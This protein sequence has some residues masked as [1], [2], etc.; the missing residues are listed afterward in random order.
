MRIFSDYYA[1]DDRIEVIAKGRSVYQRYTTRTV[2]LPELMLFK[3]G[4]TTPSHWMG[5]NGTIVLSLPRTIFI[6]KLKTGGQPRLDGPTGKPFC[7]SPC[8]GA[9]C[10]YRA[11]IQRG[12][13]PVFS[14]SMKSFVVAI[15]YIDAIQSHPMDGL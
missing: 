9:I 11:A 12:W 8:C 2:E 10:G 5:L 14:L 6:D 7:S 15:N 3:D 4:K 1:D 13:P